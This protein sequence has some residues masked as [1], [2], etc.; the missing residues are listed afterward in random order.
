MLAGMAATV[1]SPI[2]RP[3]GSAG[4]ARRRAIFEEGVTAIEQ[5]YDQDRLSVVDLA[6]TIFT[7]K[8]QLQ[9]A[10]AEAGTSFQA[11]LQAVRIERSA[12]LLVESSLPVSA[13]AGLVGYRSPAQF[14]K[15]F[16]VHYQLTPTQLRSINSNPSMNEVIAME[17]KCGCK[18]H[19]P[20]GRPRPLPKRDKHQREHERRIQELDRRLKGLDRAA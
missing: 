2:D 20:Q 19:P 7:S 17:C 12:E 18:T 6:Q 13:I 8:R 10:F 4:A 11:T 15:A 14:A 3:P 9:R 1:T 5:R 16:R